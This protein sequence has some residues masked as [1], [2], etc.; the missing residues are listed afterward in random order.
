MELENKIVVDHKVKKELL[1][2]ATYPTIRKALKGYVNTPQALKIR[3]AA[4]DNGGVLI[5][6]KIKNDDKNNI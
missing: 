4:L 6:P 2:I 5:I 3:Q 1:S